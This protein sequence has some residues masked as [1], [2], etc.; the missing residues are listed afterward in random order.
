MKFF[1]DLVKRNNKPN[2]I[3]VITKASG[4]QTTSVQEV[5]AEFISY[6]QN[7]MWTITCCSDLDNTMV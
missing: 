6:F 3:V 5:A 7:L 1:H 4:E 2:A